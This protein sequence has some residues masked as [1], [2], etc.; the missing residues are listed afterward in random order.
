[1][2]R[3]RFRKQN[4]RG[5]YCKIFFLL[6]KTDRHAERN[7][8]KEIE[9]QTESGRERDSE[10]KTETERQTKREREIGDKK[11]VLFGQHT[12]RCG[13]SIESIYLCEILP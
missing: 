13:E 7:S 6:R 5:R 1:M 12:Y 9:R 11:Q 4:Y 3:I 10:R 2:Q 8:K